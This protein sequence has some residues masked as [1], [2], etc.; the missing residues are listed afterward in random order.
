MILAQLVLACAGSGEPGPPGG[1][2]NPEQ[3]LLVW[4]KRPSELCPNPIIKSG[5]GRRIST[6][7]GDLAIGDLDG[8][9]LDDAVW[10]EEV[11]PGP[12]T[13]DQILHTSLGASWTVA[14]AT[15]T[16][17]IDT[18]QHPLA[19]VDVDGDGQDE[20]VLGLW[21]YGGGGY[22]P[23]DSGSKQIDAIGVYD[24]D[25]EQLGMWTYDRSNLVCLG[26]IQTNILGT[27]AGD[28]L[29]HSPVHGAWTVDG[30]SGDLDVAAGQRVVGGIQTSAL[31][32][33]DGDGASEAI[34]VTN[35]SRYTILGF[36]NEPPVLLSAQGT[37]F[38]SPYGGLESG[39]DLTG[40]GSDD[41]VWVGWLGVDGLPWGMRILETQGQ[42][43]AFMSDVQKAQ[44]LRDLDGDGLGELAIVRL[45]DANRTVAVFR[46]PIVGELFLEDAWLQLEVPTGLRFPSVEAADLD[47]DGSPELLIGTDSG[48]ESFE[49]C[50]P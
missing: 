16:A 21:L 35:A 36:D 2:T 42:I 46:S 25:G 12:F 15:G 1:S 8:D 28:L 7:P 40:N 24:R 47:H 6:A 20:I 13:Y 27:S 30:F 3:P 37:H 26:D 17:S 39:E 49:L 9:G 50:P 44:P 31:G 48:W 11:D 45:G 10:L 32:D 4:P 23:C 29:L 22:Y 34:L 43:L 33:L 41:I 14:G 38:A 18:A 19:L 5:L